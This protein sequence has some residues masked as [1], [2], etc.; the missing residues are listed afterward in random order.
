MSDKRVHPTLCSFAG[1]IKQIA[2]KECV[3]IKFSFSHYSSR[4]T[5]ASAR[6]HSAPEKVLCSVRVWFPVSLA[7]GQQFTQPLL[8]P[9]LSLGL[10]LSLFTSTWPG[11]VHMLTMIALAMAMD[12][13]VPRRIANNCTSSRVIFWYRSASWVSSLNATPKMRCERVLHLHPC[14]HG[15]CFIADAC[16]VWEMQF[17]IV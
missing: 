4:R 3:L 16:H 7:D 9:S 5:N 10:S 11:T 15:G 6:P 14:I 1:H 2:A 13:R 8:A 12:F 17:V